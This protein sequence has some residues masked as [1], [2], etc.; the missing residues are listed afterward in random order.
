MKLNL[1]RVGDYAVPEDGFGGLKD[2][3]LFTADVKIVR[4]PEF[5]RKFWKMLRIV[6]AN[7]PEQHQFKTAEAL[8]DELLFRAGYY[9]PFLTVSGDMAYKVKSISYESLD[10]LQFSELYAR[11]L[12][13]GCKMIGVISEE[14]EAEIDN[15]S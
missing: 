5:H 14:L 15:L 2:G 12:D 8:K 11:V 9:T 6:L 7:L 13:E 1:K 3:C 10:N 4:S